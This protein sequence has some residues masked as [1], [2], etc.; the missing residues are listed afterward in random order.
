M[1][2]LQII[3][4]DLS[5]IWFGCQDVKRSTCIFLGEAEGRRDSKYIS[6]VSSFPNQ[7]SQFYKINRVLLVARKK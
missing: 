6:I 1:Y 7:H 5:L 4:N 2:F 3:W